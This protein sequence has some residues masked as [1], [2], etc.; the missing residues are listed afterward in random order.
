VRLN[1][2]DD[3]LFEPGTAAADRAVMGFAAGALGAG[4]Q[5]G[6][7]GEF[8]GRVKARDGTDFSLE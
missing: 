5:T 7:G 4:N 2:L 3:D 6:A 8:L 1:D